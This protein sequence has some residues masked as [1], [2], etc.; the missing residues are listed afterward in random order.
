[1]RREKLETSMAD[2]M[3]CKRFMSSR[4]TGAVNITK[5]TASGKIPKTRFDCIVE[6][7]ESTRPRMESVMK[8][9]REDHIAG[10]G[11]NSTLQHNLVHK[12]IPMPQVMKIPD[13]KAA[14]DKEWKKT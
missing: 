12:F 10:K 9:N 2:P 8:K 14:V 13:A 6:A 1:M 11:Q 7:H 4:G 3:P 5:V